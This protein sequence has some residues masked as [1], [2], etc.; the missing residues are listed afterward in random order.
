ML[1]ML[2]LVLSLHQSRLLANIE[3]SWVQMP[4]PRRDDALSPNVAI[5][6]QQHMC[7]SLVHFATEFIAWNVGKTPSQRTRSCKTSQKQIQNTPK[8]RLHKENQYIPEPTPRKNEERDISRSCVSMKQQIQEHPPAACRRRRHCPL[9]EP[10]KPPQRMGLSVEHVLV[11]NVNLRIRVLQ[12]V[13]ILERL[14][15]EEALH[16]VGG[17]LLRP[18][19]VPDRAIRDVHLAV[20]LY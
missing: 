18:V 9:L 16:L 12:Q 20:P 3:E 13:Q 2:P 6:T 17:T 10:V 15:K 7:I 5:D 1:W 11:Q 14:G 4:L 19:N 8:I